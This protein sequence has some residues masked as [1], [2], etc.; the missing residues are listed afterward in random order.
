MVLG[1][2]T[3]HP[4]RLTNFRNLQTNMTKRQKRTQTTRSV[5]SLTT[6]DVRN[7]I[8]GEAETKRF[9]LVNTLN[10]NSTAGTVL[11]LSN[12]IIQGDDI[13]QRAGDKIR[14]TKQILRVRATAITN[15]QT[16]RFI[17]FKD[18]TNRG[19]TPSV[20]EVLNSAS[21]MAQYN[22]VTLLQHRFTI[23]KD[24]ELDCSLS[25]ESIK[26]LVMTHGGTSCF[27]NGTTAVASANGPGAI[28][29]LVI[30]DS[31]VGTWDVGYE[32][33]YLDL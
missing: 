24:V 5:R 26:H 14:M 9:V 18:N 28:F 27:Y 4:E 22:P 29:L 33:H 11:N 23:L 17:W 31:I 8:R 19:T 30:G 16:F 25:G 13:S 7:I 12:G 15:S 1:W 20:T 6:R 21:F 3:H 2:W 10:L 32:A